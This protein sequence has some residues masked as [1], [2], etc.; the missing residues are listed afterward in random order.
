MIQR[1]FWQKEENVL[2]RRMG[3]YIRY[4]L[5]I[6][7]IKTSSIAYGQVQHTGWLAS[8]NT[9]KL[10]SKTS[11]HFDAQLR[12]ADDLKFIQT[13]LLRP[14]INYH[15]NP[16]MSATAGYGLIETRSLRFNSY[17]VLTEHRIW[18]QFIKTH[19]VNNISAMHR[20]RLEQRFFPNQILFSEKNTSHR[21]RY[22]IRNIVPL[23]NRNTF[24]NGLFFALQDEVFLNIANQDVVNGKTFDQNRLYLAFGYR[25]PGK[26]DLEAGYMNQYISTRTNFI[27]NHIAQLALYKRL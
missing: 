2:I 16:S 23:Q 22:F 15:F 6:M 19:K 4:F 1:K 17:Q 14:G 21:F 27:N 7:F 26:I 9:F 13:L 12:S 18:E 24:S 8:F 10:S 5:L 11:L 25:L 20:F 3:T